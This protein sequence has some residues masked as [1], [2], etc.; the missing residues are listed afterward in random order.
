MIQRIQ[1]IFLFMAAIVALLLFFFPFAH[2]IVPDATSHYSFYP[3]GITVYGE[4]YPATTIYWALLVL[5]TGVTLLPVI[6]LLAYKKQQLQL[7]LCLLDVILVLCSTALMWY[8]I[9]L[10]APRPEGA[11]ITYTICF[12]FP[13]ISAVFIWLATRGIKKDVQLLKSYDRI[14]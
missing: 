10:F 4:E 5:Y 11:V 8:H 12:I 1:T 3:Y 7:R 2:L 9:H 14:R 6:A 13:L